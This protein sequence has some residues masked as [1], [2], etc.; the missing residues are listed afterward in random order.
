MQLFFMLCN[1]VALHP[2]V[3]LQLANNTHVN[4]TQV[5]FAQCNQFCES[6][7]AEK[8]FAIMDGSKFQIAQMNSVTSEETADDI[9]ELSSQKAMIS[10]AIMDGQLQIAGLN[11]VIAKATTDT[12][13]LASEIEL[14]TNDIDELSSQKAMIQEDLRMESF[15]ADHNDYFSEFEDGHRA[16]AQ[17]LQSSIDR[18]INERSDKMALKSLRELAKADAQAS[19]L[20][21]TA[22]VAADMQ[23]LAI[24]NKETIGKASEY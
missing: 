7:S 18:A 10:R 16:L 24:L 5:N 19:L 22:F 3:M 9:A 20:D 1:I 4:N 21:T 11:A 23:Y 13:S 14:L 2:T 6:A 12:N 17:D 15:T 8:S